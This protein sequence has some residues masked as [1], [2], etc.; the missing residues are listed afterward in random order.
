[1]GVWKGCGKIGYMTAQQV[2]LFKFSTLAASKHGKSCKS[3]STACIL[4]NLA[5]FKH[6]LVHRHSN[7]ICFIDIE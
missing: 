4:S 3:K 5:R 2:N 7:I 1:M 6:I